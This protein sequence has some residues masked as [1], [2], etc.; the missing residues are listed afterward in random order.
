MP[1]GVHYKETTRTIRQE[2][3]DK[4]RRAFAPGGPRFTSDLVGDLIVCGPFLWND[5]QIQAPVANPPQKKVIF[6]VSI[7]PIAMVME[8]KRFLASEAGPFLESLNAYTRGQSF[9]LRAPTSKELELYWHEV[10][11]DL[12]APIIVLES[13]KFTFLADFQGRTTINLIEQLRPGM[14]DVKLK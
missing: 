5:L 10:P 12:E 3:L 14:A 13:L 1:P 4:L 7:G 9:S 8:S 2:A 6:Q 11:Y